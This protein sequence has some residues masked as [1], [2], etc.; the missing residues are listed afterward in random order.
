MQ[1]NGAKG[2]LHDGVE[3]YEV[4]AG[5]GNYGG[6]CGCGERRGEDGVVLGR[7]SG[8]ELKDGGG[9]DVVRDNVG[10]G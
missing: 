3:P 6:T 2:L 1:R 9:V 7:G 8:D 4:G 10:A 5:S